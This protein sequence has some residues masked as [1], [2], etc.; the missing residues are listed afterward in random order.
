MSGINHYAISKIL[1]S[2]M[3]PV[4]GTRFGGF[5]VLATTAGTLK[6]VREANSESAARKFDLDEDRLVASAFEAVRNGAST[7]ALLW[8]KDLAGRFIARCREV[9][10]AFPPASLVRR[11]IHIRK[12]PKVYGRH[13]ITLS[14]TTRS[15]P[16][17]SIVPQY[18]HVIE[19][20]LVRLRYRHGAAIDTILAD[21]ELAQEFETLALE[22]APALTGEQ[23]RLGALYI[24]KT[25]HFSKGDVEK[26]LALNPT[27]VEQAMSESVSLARV[28]TEEVPSAPGLLELKEGERYLYVARN[29]NLRPAVEQLRTG[30]AFSVVAN[31]FWQPA[32]EAI[33]LRYVEGRKVEGISTT[34]WE[35]RLIQAREPILNWPMTKKEEAA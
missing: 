29:D 22:V 9:G 3:R 21:P 25:R 4:Q 23:L 35:L 13:G 30:R 18:A 26:A 20:A 5:G 33:T 10:L 1:G 19:F 27:Q 32:L 15:E 17:L 28:N 31:G 6:T 7:D 12:S 24:R 8:D 2:E 14:P 34:R 11:V 16:H